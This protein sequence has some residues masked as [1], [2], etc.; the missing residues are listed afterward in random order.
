MSDFKWAIFYLQCS[1]FPSAF[2]NV[3]YLAVSGTISSCIMSHPILL[4]DV[5]I[6]LDSPLGIHNARNVKEIKIYSVEELMK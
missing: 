4:N 3:L 1:E 6:L 2:C 5:T